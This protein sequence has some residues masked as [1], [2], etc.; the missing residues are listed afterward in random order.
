MTTLPK[1]KSC[2]SFEKTSG[3]AFQMELCR[4]LDR[5]EIYYLMFI[6]KLYLNRG[7]YIDK[8]KADFNQYF[9]LNS[10]ILV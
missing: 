8:M 7:V 3:F 5:I 2:K 4:R 10:R 6:K 9:L 1:N